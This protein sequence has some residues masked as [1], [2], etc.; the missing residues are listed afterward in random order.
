LKRW[1]Q[2]VKIK[3]PVAMA[4]LHLGCAP[5]PALPMVN[6]RRVCVCVFETE[7]ERA[8]GKKRGE[9]WDRG[10]W[11]KKMEGGHSPTP[12]FTLL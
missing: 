1:T 10:G 2:L 12:T 3:L 6:D 8:E 9:G 5:E 4:P 11:G 7:V